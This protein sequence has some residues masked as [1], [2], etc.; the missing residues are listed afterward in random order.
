MRR[1]K[2]GLGCLAGILVIIILAMGIKPQKTVDETASNQETTNTIAIKEGEIRIA[3]ID[4]GVSSLA[5]DKGTIET[6]YNYVLNNEDVEDRIGHGSAVTSAILGSNLAGIDGVY[7][8]AT[9]VPLV[10]QTRDDNGEESTAS[11]ET[12]GHIIRDAIDKYHC[13]IINLSWGLTVGS[14]D[15]R[16]ATEYAEM[17]GVTILS[18]VGN[19]YQEVGEQLHYPAAY[20]NVIGIGSINTDNRVSDFS[21]RNESVMFVTYGEGYY[22]STETGKQTWANG[23]S[24]A[25]ALATG[26]VAKIYEK[27][28]EMQPHEVRAIL[29]D[30]AI[31]LGVEGYDI[32]SGYGQ[33]NL[34]KAIE[35]L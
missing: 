31:D 3:V 23:T 7:E 10:F 27:S 33:I 18:A 29:K 34:T 6:G 17:C 30:T 15:I 14:E 13:K 8:D 16:E 35:K 19:N 2:I 28:P 25:T 24:Y 26:A 1:Y 9:I 12:I 20:P 21:Q 32:H 11:L 4:T 22:L 5:N